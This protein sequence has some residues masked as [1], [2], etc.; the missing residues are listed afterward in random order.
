MKRPDGKTPRLLMVTQ[1]F[2]PEPTFKG[3]VFAKALQAKGFDVEVVTGFPNYPGGKLYPGYRIR[4]WQREIM[5]GVTV[6][7]LPLYPSHDKSAIFRALNYLSFFFSLLVYLVLFARRADIAYVYHPPL[8]VGLAAA[9]ARALRRTPT[10]LDIQD[11]WPDTMRA[12]GMVGSLR[13]LRVIGAACDWLY[14]HVD[15]LVVLSPGFKRVLIGRNV[16]EG[17][18]TQ[19]YNWAEEGVLRRDG[20]EDVPDAMKPDGKFRVLFAGNM[21]RA[22][23][24]DAVLDAAKIVAGKV[25][26]VEF[27][28]LG[29]GI[30]LDR[31]KSRADTEAI[32]NVRFLPK[33]S[34]AES[35]RYLAAAGALLVHLT[36]DP[37]FEITIPSKIQAYMV[38]GRPIVMAVSG[39]AASLVESSGGGVLAQSEDPYSIAQA[40]MELA[41]MK[42]TSRQKMA[43]NNRAFYLRELSLDAGVTAFSNLFTR[44]M[45]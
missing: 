12:T 13:L 22:Q 41:T 21:G 29:A 15:H 18:I 2:D 1:W 40:V 44:L 9:L 28:F 19:I 10:V 3:L 8:T 34:I 32:G 7:R 36:R 24:L 25:Q 5:D 26:N 17:R 45:R 11:L 43:D 30:E 37:L 16:S 14:R 33:V 23:G 31:L 20:Q 42:E 6:I 27:C 35:S 39:D 4:P 38:A